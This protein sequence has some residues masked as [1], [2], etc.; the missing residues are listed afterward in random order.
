MKLPLILAC[1]TACIVV[2]SAND[3]LDI[4]EGNKK[5]DDVALPPLAEGEQAAAE[6]EKPAVFVEKEWTPNPVLD[7]IW[8]RAVLYDNEANPWIQQLAIMGFFEY[9]AAWGEAE[10]EGAGNYDLDTNRVRRARLGTRMKIFGNTEIEAVGEFAGDSEFQRIE[11]LKGRTELPRDF[12]VDYGKFRPHFGIEGSKDPQELL[13]PDRSLLTSML[14]PASTLGAS[15]SQKID[16]WEWHLGWFSGDNDRYLPGFQGN[17]FIA[18]GLAYTADERIEGGGV[19]RTRWHADYINNM[20]HRKSSSLPRYD[21]GGLT[22]VNGPQGPVSNPAFRHLFSTGVELEGDRFGFE[23]DFLLANGDL[24]A[25]G[26]TLLPSYWILPER[27]QL[28]GRYHYADTDAPGGLVGTLGVGG[29]PLYDTSPLFVG[30]EFHSFYLGANAHFYQDK[31]VWLNGLEYAIMKDQ[32]GAG[33]DTDAWIWHSA[34]R[35][36]F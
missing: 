17:G 34:A 31:L 16:A 24:N 14:M 15:V 29:D 9:G 3:A 11:R 2:A 7:P 25:W 1:V 20:D 32:G 36:S 26:M 13:T 12:A 35:I 21:V 33:F 18:A 6:E 5:V 8:S 19:M 23:G 4:L 22:A 27:L 10:V 30:D 28:V